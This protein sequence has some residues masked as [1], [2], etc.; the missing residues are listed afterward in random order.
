MTTAIRSKAK[1]PTIDSITIKHILDDC[2]DTSW[3]GKYSD[4]WENGVIKR[5]NAERNEYKYF[6]PG[7]SYTDHWEALHKIGYSKG[8][9][10]YLARKY[11]YEDYK[12]MESLNNGDICFIGIIAEATILIPNSYGTY[13]QSQRI[14]SGGLWG[15]ESDSDKSYIAEVETEQLADLKDQLKALGISTR[16]FDKIEVQRKEL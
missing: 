3:I 15:I 4:Q 1:K 12:R 13:S 10:D 8:D 7:N 14:T 6:I 11:N 16:N 2:P 9:C 5:Y